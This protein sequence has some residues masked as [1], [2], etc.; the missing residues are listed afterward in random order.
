MVQDS[1]AGGHA[2]PGHDNFRRRN[3]VDALGLVG[4]QSEM[5]IFK[6]KNIRPG[7]YVPMRFPV[8]IIFVFF[9]NLGRLDRQRRV[10]KNRSS[11]HART[12][13]QII[14]FKQEFLRALQRESRNHQNASRL[15]GIFQS[16]LQAELAF[17]SCFMQ[18]VA[19]G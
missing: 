15:H 1:P 7:F 10:Q 9:I 16:P 18:A 5:D 3:V 13:H 8:E 19:V 12:L 14:D 4:G 17:A 11:G 6:L 2:R